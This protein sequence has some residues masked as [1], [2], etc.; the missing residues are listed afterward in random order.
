MSSPYLEE[1]FQALPWFKELSML[2]G[3]FS[4]SCLEGVT[5]GALLPKVRKLS[6]LIDT[7]DGFY[8]HLD[9]LERRKSDSSHAAHVAA[10]TFV[11]RSGVGDSRLSRSARCKE[12][13][14]LGWKIRIVKYR[15]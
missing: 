15:Q 1:L 11:N 13:V 10:V 3:V 9:M 4:A 7:L 8:A 12:M 5:S 2:R 6:C 14:T